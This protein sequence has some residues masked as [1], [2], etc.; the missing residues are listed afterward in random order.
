MIGKSRGWE[1]PREQ[2]V[3]VSL[4]VPV[5]N[6][7]L[8]RSAEPISKPVRVLPLQGS[9]LLP[10]GEAGWYRGIFSSRQCWLSGHF[11]NL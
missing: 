5:L 1:Q 10:L 4:R 3:G 11:F 6:V 9:E 7:A 8:E 2:T